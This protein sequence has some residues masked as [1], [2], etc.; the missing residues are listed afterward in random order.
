MQEQKTG[1][2]EAKITVI[3]R[4]ARSALGIG[5]A[6]LAEHLGVSQSTIARCER[7]AGT[8]PANV[9]LRAIRFFG[10]HGIDITGL[11]EEVPTISFD[12]AVFKAAMNSPFK[13]SLAFVDEHMPALAKRP[14]GVSP[15]AED[16]EEK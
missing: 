9:L 2:D 10:Q 13:N 11:L 4:A 16:D 3:L 1:L 6:D 7:G 14:P 5:Q 8:I 15:K 12:E